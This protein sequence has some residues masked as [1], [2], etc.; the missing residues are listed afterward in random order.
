VG[1]A[2]TCAT[3]DGC[4]RGG[5]GSGGVGARWGQT[6][7][8]AFAGH[9]G[10]GACGAGRAQRTPRQRRETRHSQPSRSERC[11]TGVGRSWRIRWPGRE[12]S[13]LWCAAAGEWQAHPQGQ[14]VASLP[15]VESAAGE[16]GG[17]RLGAGRAAEGRRVLDLTRVLAGPVATRTLAAW[18]AEVLRLDSH[19]TCCRGSALLDFADPADRPVLERLLGEADVLVQG[20][21]PGALSHFGLSADALTERHPH[22]S[23]VTLSAWGA[24]GPLVTTPRLRL[25]GAVPDR[26]RGGRGRRRKARGFARPARFLTTLPGATRPVQVVSPPGQA[27]DLL[28]KWAFTTELGVDAPSF[29]GG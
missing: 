27:G 5:L 6:R 7:A 16:G 26:D 9:A 11:S 24:S 23:V 3:G 17:R 18:G 25:L 10:C 12:H 19:W 15:L 29:D 13:D 8:L 22:L 20:Y 2:V 4:R 28:P 21:R 1:V 14:A